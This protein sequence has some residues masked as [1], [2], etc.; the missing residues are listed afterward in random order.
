MSEQTTDGDMFPEGSPQWRSQIVAD[1][2]RLR[3]ERDALASRCQQ[4][5]QR[6]QRLLAKLEE[7]RVM[8][9]DAIGQFKAR[10]QHLET[11]LYQLAR[12]IAPTCD[13]IEDREFFTLDELVKTARN[14][15]ELTNDRCEELAAELDEARH[16]ASVLSTAKAEVIT[17]LESRCQHLEQAIRR[18]MKESA[19]IDALAGEDIRELVGFDSMSVWRSRIEEAASLLSPQNTIPQDDQDDQARAHFSAGYSQAIDDAL[20]P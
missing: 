20:K 15:R 1:M 2:D 18:L 14:H 7:E 9:S 11:G 12:A 13:T 4:L 19:A 6:E 16:Q 8:A 5:E 3:A 10:C 17:G